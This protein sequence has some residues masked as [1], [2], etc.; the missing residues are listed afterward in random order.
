[1]ATIKNIIENGRST[2]NPKVSGPLY[3]YLILLFAIYNVNISK[4]IKITT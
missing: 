1:M 2:N 4:I 3:L